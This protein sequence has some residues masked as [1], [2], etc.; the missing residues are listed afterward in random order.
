VQLTRFELVE[1]MLRCLE[2]AV[3]GRPVEA[4]RF[5]VC[6]FEVECV[7]VPFDEVGKGESSERMC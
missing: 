5:D 4:V 3:E 2:E 1:E 6:W 7:E